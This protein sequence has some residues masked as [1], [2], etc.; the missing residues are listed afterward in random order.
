VNLFGEGDRGGSLS[1]DEAV[2]PRERV[3]GFDVRSDMV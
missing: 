2:T 3:E 1:G